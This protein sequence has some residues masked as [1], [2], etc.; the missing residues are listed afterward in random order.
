MTDDPRFKALDGLLPSGRT[1]SEEVISAI[2]GYYLLG[3]SDLHHMD[4]RG[5]ENEDTT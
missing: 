4:I 5:V 3:L 1:V 2:A